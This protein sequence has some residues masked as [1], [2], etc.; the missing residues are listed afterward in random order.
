MNYGVADPARLGHTLLP[1]GRRL[2][3]AEWGPEE[4]TAVLLCPGAATSR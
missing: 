1:D 2:A 4:G 3:W